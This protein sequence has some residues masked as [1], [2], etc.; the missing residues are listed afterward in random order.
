MVPVARTSRR[1]TRAG[2]PI[3]EARSELN[4]ARFEYVLATFA[5]RSEMPTIIKPKKRA[6]Q[7]ASV[8]RRVCNSYDQQH[9]LWKTVE[10]W[11]DFWRINPGRTNGCASGKG[12]RN[13]VVESKRIGVAIRA[14]SVRNYPT[15]SVASLSLFDVLHVDKDPEPTEFVFRASV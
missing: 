1:G 8:G 3:Q 6:Q 15:S 5:K 14:A 11:R 4:A 7:C 12:E 10:G 9:T 13:R 2:P